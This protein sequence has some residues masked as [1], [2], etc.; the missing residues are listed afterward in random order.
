M[1]WA[2]LLLFWQNGRFGSCIMMHELESERDF[3]NEQPRIFFFALLGV[4]CMFSFV[5]SFVR[6]FGMNEEEH[7]TNPHHIFICAT[8]SGHDDISVERSLPQQEQYV[9]MIKQ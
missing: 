1:K 3:F 8:T 6:D 7:D 4:G 2:D 9:C 5:F